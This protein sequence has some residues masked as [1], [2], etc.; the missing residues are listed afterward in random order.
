MT[1]QTKRQEG[2]KAAAKPSRKIHRYWSP[3]WTTWILLA[4]ILFFA[5]VRFRLRDIPLE[6]DEGEYA[7]AGQ[8]MQQ[9]IP[10]YQLA[11]NM[12]LPGTYA[13]FAL[14]MAV[15]GDTSGGIHLGFL[16]VNAATAVLVFL[17]GRKLFGTA[18]GAVSGMTYEVLSASTAVLGLE[19]HATHFVI[20]AALAGILLLTYALE[21]DRAVYFFWSGTCLGLAF[22]MK[23]PGAVFALF[24]L[25][26]LVYRKWERHSDW[27][28]MI[29]RG[30][31]LLAGT[32]WPFVVTC[33]LLYRAGVFPAFWF[34]TFTYARAYGSIIHFA[35]AV[36]RFRRSTGDLFRM[37]GP[38]W[39]IAGIGLVIL[40]L[41]RRTRSQSVF[42][43]GLLTFSF[44]G[45]SAGLYYRSHYFVL[46][47][48]A[49]ALLCGLA[50]VPGTDFFRKRFSSAAW[51]AI[52]ILLFSAALAFSVVRQGPVFF[53]GS[54]QVANRRIY[55]GNPFAEAGEVAEFIKM[56]SSPDA[57]IAI[58]GSE[59]EIYFY[60]QRKSATG[61]IYTY[62]L[63]EEQQFAKQMQ[64][65]MMREVVSARP[66]YVVFVDD[67]L[68]WGW[69]P[70]EQGF[71]RQILLYINDQ[72]VKAGEVEIL[73]NPEHGIGD[74]SKMYVFRRKTE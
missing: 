8:L 39:C 73:G 25:A 14:I 37:D 18:V 72:Y 63:M 27:R 43:I 17:L 6:R 28:Y 53:A 2:K 1:V 66:E 26:Y 50:V 59:P 3:H 32:I 47:L 45:V 20:F 41:N 34:W 31:A 70:S 22:L 56:Y 44:L 12:K 13:A 4:V 7:Y 46:L 5:G 29:S 19:A 67:E 16:I 74:S 38:L 51:A 36:Y 55:Y 68:S 30:G 35:E 71:I 15:F 40:F 69:R 52:P 58:F 54:P 24:A 61:Y 49:A 21:S 33:L 11:Y 65:E 64:Q 57:R 10:P 23:Q 48:P 60:A 9:G 62:A 42:L